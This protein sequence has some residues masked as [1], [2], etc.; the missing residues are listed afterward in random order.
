MRFQHHVH[1]VNH[2][3]EWRGGV[4]TVEH[5]SSGSSLHRVLGCLHE[6]TRELA[7]VDPLRGPHVDP[8][9]HAQ[10]EHVLAALAQAHT[11][12]RAA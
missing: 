1:W 10:A 2:H 6:G 3:Q 7:G 11:L 5:V 8:V 4:R 12:Q 9:R